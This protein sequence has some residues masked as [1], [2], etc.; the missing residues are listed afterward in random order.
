MRKV[1]SRAS[2]PATTSSLEVRAITTKLKLSGPRQKSAA[3]VEVLIY[4]RICL[5][6][7]YNIYHSFK[8]KVTIPFGL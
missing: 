1:A 6:K 3:Q 5:S 4:E 8:Y 7:S 2:N